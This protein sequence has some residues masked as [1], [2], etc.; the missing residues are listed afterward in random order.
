MKKTLAFFA[1]VAVLVIAP[2]FAEAKTD[3]QVSKFDKQIAV[4]QKKIDRLVALREKRIEALAAKGIEVSSGTPKKVLSTELRNVGADDHIQ[5]NPNAR[6]VL[7]EYS[8]LECPFCKLHHETMNKIIKEYGASGKVAW[9]YRHLPLEQLHP[10]AAK[11]AEASE[12]VAELGGESAFWKFT[13]TLFASRSTGDFTN[14]KKIEGYASAAGVNKKAFQKC[15]EEGTYA[16]KIAESVAE[17]AA[18][19][20]RGTPHTF[21][22]VDRKNVSAIEGAQPYSEVR[23]VVADLVAQ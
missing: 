2:S 18:L 22:V 8:D 3:A 16:D 20:V 17:A 14:M 5:G 12:C 11:L 1:L 15:R 23:K 9:V 6:V 21:V 4:L 13:N 7:I 19:G 10:N